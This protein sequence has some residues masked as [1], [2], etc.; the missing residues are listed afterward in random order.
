MRNEMKTLNR[1]SVKSLQW[2]KEQ[3]KKSELFSEQAAKSLGLTVEELRNL[4][5]QKRAH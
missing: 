2:H 3:A 1:V 5:K 4:G